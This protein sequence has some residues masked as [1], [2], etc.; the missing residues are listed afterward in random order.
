MGRVAACLPA[1]LCLAASVLGQTDTR[2][3]IL[4]PVPGSTLPGA[5]VTFTWTHAPHD[6]FFRVGSQPFV[7][8][9]IF[10]AEVTVTSLTLTNV[11][12]DGRTIYVEL[13]TNSP[14]KVWLEPFRYT[15]TAANTNAP[16][17]TTL[18]AVTDS[19]S[20]G[21]SSIA[22]GQIVTL[23][24]TGMGPTGLTY[25]ALDANNRFPTSAAGARILFNGIPAPMIYASDKQ[26]AAIVPFEL[27][28]QATAQVQVE[29]N[30]T[31]SAPMTLPV[32]GAM[33]GIFA[34][35]QS[36][37]GLGA[38]QNSDL[39]YN[40]VANPAAPGSTIV[41]WVSGLGP[42]DPQP[43][44]GAIVLAPLPVL[45]HRPTVTIAGRAAEIVYAGPAPEAVAGLYQINCNIPAG[46][47]SGLAPVVVTSDG[48]TSQ[49]N[50]MV[51]I[52]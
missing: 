48:R 46:V 50:L 35:D 23:F 47:P 14:G 38:I 52:R 39:S 19:A 29:Y 2:A 51:A 6:Y 10:N 44:N 3:Q 13:Y 16:V 20:Y 9:D 21:A 37:S 22:P 32:T 28:G 41:L 12:T 33:P 7:N 34:A 4:S 42:L 8:G 27:A 17:R 5:V 45:V 49:P 25:A 31:V 11:P 40:S 26:S 1:V 36:G 15:Y 30:G 43:P 24:G 18:A